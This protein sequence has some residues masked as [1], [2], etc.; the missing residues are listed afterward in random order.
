MDN[1][2]LLA[3]SAHTINNCPYHYV[4]QET[5]NIVSNVTICLGTNIQNDVNM[6]T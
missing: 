5:I 6:P 4:L 2:D 3:S 1:I